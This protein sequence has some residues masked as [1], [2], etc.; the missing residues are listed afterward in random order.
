MSVAMERQVTTKD[1]LAMEPNLKSR[2]SVDVPLGSPDATLDGILKIRTLPFVCQCQKPI[3]IL[4][5]V[6]PKL[7]LSYHW[8]VC[9]SVCLFVS[10][11]E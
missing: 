2:H 8:F 11:Y 5:I 3:F 10:Y 9:L 7:Y 1:Q 6:I 4:L